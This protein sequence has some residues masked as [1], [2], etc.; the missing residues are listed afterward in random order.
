MHIMPLTVNR[1][2]GSL[3]IDNSK[4]NKKLDFQPPYTTEV[5]IQAMIE[6]DINDQHMIK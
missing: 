2:W 4:T 5:G 1:I 3:E 6:W